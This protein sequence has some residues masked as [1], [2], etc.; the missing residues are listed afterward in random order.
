MISPRPWPGSLL[1]QMVL[2][3][4]AALFVAQGINFW[5]LLQGG[6]SLR[7]AE[8]V[9]PAVTRL[10]AAV[11]RDQATR[12]VP[13]GRRIEVV[14][15]PPIRPGDVRRPDIEA[16]L[17]RAFTDAGTIPPAVHVV[18]RRLAPGDIPR[19]ASRR[20]RRMLRSGG[21]LVLAAET[22]PG[23]WLVMRAPWPRFDWA[24]V[25]RLA[26]QTV[27]IYAVVLAAVVWIG[28]RIARPLAAL[29]AAARA[30]NPQFPGAPL[31]ESGPADLRQLIA[32]FNALRLRVAAMLTEKDRMLG[33]IG[34]DLRTPLAAL[35]VR[36]ESVD[37][38]SDRQRMAETIETM[39]AMLD[40][41][42]SFA[43]VGRGE[44]AR[45]D[46]DLNAL[47]EAVVEDF[48]DLG[49]NVAFVPTGRTILAVRPAALQRAIRNLIEN[50]IKYAGTG[51]VVLS[52][53]TMAVEVAV[54]DRGPGIPPADIERVFEPFSRLESSRN[55]ETGGSGLGLALAR[56]IAGEAG[57][58]LTLANRAGGGLEA[59]IRLPRTPA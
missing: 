23:R 48:R 2:L 12:I 8:I 17:L 41:I 4:A 16:A 40:D 11:E 20:D 46:T 59:V 36:I 22:A 1:G 26:L 57:G 10:V 5:F 49:A 3:V 51:E 43:R 42:L 31:S 27:V 39:N 58:T 30:F 14:S 21:Q 25:G 34:H 35:R 9:G 6:R 44:E 47:V 15:R 38:A 37:D 55:R 18:A 50:A 45:S 19:P 33:A 56:A 52:E 53:T 7:Q 13:R 32:A 54:L 24:L 29:T 28:R